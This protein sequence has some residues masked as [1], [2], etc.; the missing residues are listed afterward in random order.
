MK[1]NFTGMLGAATQSAGTAI[2]ML[3]PGRKHH[4]TSIDQIQIKAGSTAH[5]VYLMNAIP[6]P[7][8]A[9]PTNYQGTLPYPGK[10][11]TCAG[12]AAA[13]QAVVNVTAAFQDAAANAA[14]TGDYFSVK[15]SD[16]TWFSGT[17]TLSGSGKILTF[18]TNLPVAALA[19]A[20]VMYHALS[21]NAFH[22]NYTL[23]PPTSATTTFPTVASDASLITS[24]IEDA[25]ILIYDAN[26]TAA[27]IIE[28]VQYSHSKA[29]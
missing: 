8:I 29:A 5:T 13:G 18:G 26:G 3:V 10:Q 27:D 21:S 14:V 24:M 19:G 17:A 7:G 15:L 11:P 20:P 25:P 9:A 12:G 4:F 28:Y 22:A 23:T 1:R 2:T 16:G 6:Q